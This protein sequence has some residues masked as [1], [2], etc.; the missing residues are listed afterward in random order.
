MVLKTYLMDLK[1][2]LNKSGRLDLKL[3]KAHTLD[4]D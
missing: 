4:T 2:F 3:D 1:L